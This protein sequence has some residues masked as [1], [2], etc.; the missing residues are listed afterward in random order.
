MRFVTLAFPA[1]VAALPR[2][3]D[4]DIDMVIAAPDPTYTETPG[5][6][7]QIVTY[8]TTAIAA[9]ATAAASSIS[10]AVT[11]V[12]S[13][14]AANLKRAACD[15]QPTG[16]AD[17][18][19][20]TDTVAAF[21]ADPRWP[22]LASAAPTPSGF[23]QTQK[24][25]NGANSAY[26]YLGYRN[27][28]SYDSQAC[29]DICTGTLGC[30]AFNIYIERD[31]SVDPGTGC[32]NPSSVI[33]AKC[34][35]WG[36]PL[37]SDSATNTGQ[38][39]ADFQV[40]IAGSNA[41]QNNSLIIPN[42]F[43]MGDT[44][45][46]SAINAPYDGQ[47][48]NTYMGATIFTKGAFNIQACAD[49]C[50]AQTAYNLK[51]PASDGTP[52]KICNFFNTYMLYLN[53][54]STPQGQYCSL[55]TEAWDSSYGTNTG[56]YRGND[57]YFVAFS[58]TFKNSTSVAPKP[59]SG[60]V[61]GAAYQARQDMTYYAS[62]LTS[63]FKPYCSSLLGLSASVVTVTPTTT[64]TS[65]TTGTT[66]ATT[67]ACQKLAKRDSV[68]SSLLLPW[69]VDATASLNVNKRA[70]A[71]TPAV[72]TKYPA[73]VQSSACA[74]LVGQQTVASTV[75]AATV[76]V[77][78][79]TQT[80]IV[81][82]TSTVS[83]GT[84]GAPFT[85]AAATPL[86]KS[87]RVQVVDPSSAYYGQYM[88]WQHRQFGLLTFQSDTSKADSFIL[89]SNS[90]LVNGGS[91]WVLNPPRD[92]SDV[93][94]DTLVMGPTGF[95]PEASYPDPIIAV[96]SST[97]LISATVVNPGDNRNLLQICPYDPATGYGNGNLGT[98]PYLVLGSF[99]W[100]G[101]EAARLAFVP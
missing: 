29:A 23:V 75:T 73:V 59:A 58:Y 30:M 81:T 36:S 1:L 25:A 100:C 42:G 98:G 47:G 9:E 6:T 45:E 86:A 27:L 20:Q 21:S 62:Q 26:G 4:I 66:V 65:L 22:S 67:N 43:S 89:D 24:N 88:G 5:S 12:A 69:V 52:P 8:D 76:T 19:L 33:Y 85:Q 101:C 48:Y 94:F 99:I 41:Y 93:S 72:L 83:S 61:R 37:S 90:H 13:A 78:A 80:T 28:K 51:H 10:I 18:A 77:I 3:Q 15:A 56:Q 79:T 91:T 35:L 34:A 71:S 74:M 82:S 64:I 53:N 96:D 49:Y 16:V 55:Y 63:T 92:E 32:R 46:N 87:G 95:C 39:R 2:P 60:D 97:G 50:T 31:P 70:A 68:P 40:V 17:Y 84:L 7:A 11:N 57:R 14:T 38:T 44:L 54:A